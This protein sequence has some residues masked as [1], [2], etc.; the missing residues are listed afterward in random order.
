M[1]R[2]IVIASLLTAFLALS[3]PAVGQD[4]AGEVSDGKVVYMTS[5]NWPPYSG[6][7]LPGNGANVVVARKAFAAVGYELRVVFLPWKRA[8]MTAR[9]DPQF[10]GY[11]PEYYA[12][13][14]EEDFYFSDRM[15][16]GP[17]GIIEPKDKPVHWKTLDDLKKYRIGVVSGYVNTHDFDAKVSQ[18]VIKVDPVVDDKTN[19][20]KVLAGRI[21]AA[22]MDP[23]VLQYLIKSDP[24]LWGVGSKVQVNKRPLELKGL[25][26]C[27]RKGPYGKRMMELFNKGLKTFDWRKE[28]DK[29]FE[30]IFTPTQAP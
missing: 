23:M 21:D 30:W 19:L 15:G 4:A 27:F 29:Y 8:V 11:M 16:D 2:V 14:V 7:G 3:L 22:V 26:L 13:R 25:Y 6:K 1:P 24:E 17:L 9:T 10:A 18:G 20:K 5:L 12:E 28:Q